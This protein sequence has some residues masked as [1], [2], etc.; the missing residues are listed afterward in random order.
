MIISDLIMFAVDNPP[1][2]TLAL[3]S[4]DRDYAYSLAKL[5]QRGYE[6]ILLI[7]LVGAHPT[8]LA[9]ADR[10]IDWHD[11]AKGEQFE[12]STI[13]EPLTTIQ[14][15]PLVAT[16]QHLRDLGKTKPLFSH[17]GEYLA[18]KYPARWKKVGVTR[19]KDY[20][21]EAAKAGLVS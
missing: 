1:P 2:K 15:E 5:R 16:L 14:F 4:G 21:E 17:V 20:V 18:R 6:V 3:I 12:D 9:Q 7:P 13:G 11:L 10:I 19:L 8:L